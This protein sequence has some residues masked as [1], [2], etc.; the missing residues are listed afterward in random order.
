MIIFYSDTTLLQEQMLLFH[1]LQR[2]HFHDIA[3]L[4]RHYRIASFFY[5]NTIIKCLGN[6]MNKP[7]V[8]FFK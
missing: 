8:A 1:Q 5:Q 7:W 6:F 4:G 2:E 3:N